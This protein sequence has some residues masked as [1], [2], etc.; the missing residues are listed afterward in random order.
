MGFGMDIIYIYI[1]IR[2]SVDLRVY[3]GYVVTEQE[4]YM[5]MGQY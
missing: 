2:K 1:C 4:G 3:T 5:N